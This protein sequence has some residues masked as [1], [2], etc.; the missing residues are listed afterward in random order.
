L[1]SGF[2]F[3]IIFHFLLKNFLKLKKIYNYKI[4]QL[5]L[6]NLLHITPFSQHYFLNDEMFNLVSVLFITIIII[7]FFLYFIILYYIIEN[8]IKIL[9]NYEL[10]VKKIDIYEDDIYILITFFNKNNLTYYELY[11]GIYYSLKKN[12]FFIEYSKHKIIISKA[13]TDQR[14][15]NL[16]NNI[17]F[18]NFLTL[19]G[20]IDQCHLNILHLKTLNYLDD[21]I[22]YI[23][24]KI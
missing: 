6:L 19:E 16:H 4:L 9:S 20:F 1:G 22:K 11:K 17:F 24:V 23:E 2:I 8:N 12:S 10:E 5:F 15:F 7:P 18:D 3:Y 14:E 21:D 13:I